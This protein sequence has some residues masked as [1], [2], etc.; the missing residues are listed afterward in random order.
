MLLLLV[1]WLVL[2]KDYDRS[3]IWR[4]L[5]IN[6]LFFTTTSAGLIVWPAIVVTSEG[7]WMGP[8]EKFCRVGL[9]FSIPSVLLLGALWAGS[10]DWAPWYNIPGQGL[11]MNNDFLFLRNIILLLFFWACAFYFS[12]T[13]S[14]R[15]RKSSAIALILLFVITFSLN[16][17]DFI[18]NLNP[19]WHSMMIGGYVFSAG[20]YSGAVAWALLSVLAGRPDRRSLTDIGELIVSFCLMTTYL[21]FSQLLPI[22]YENLPEESTFLVPLLNFAWRKI[23]WVVVAVVYLSPVILLMTKWSKRSYLF[24][25][26]VSIILLAGLWVEKWWLVTAVFEKNTV[27]I[28]WPELLA[29]GVCLSFIVSVFPLVAGYDVK[30][31]ITV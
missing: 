31:R 3:R 30:E 27:V 16:G 7:E 21:M 4:T 25:G 17:F 14:A 23:S 2:A 12:F 5:L 10:P 20:L 29:A 28:G 8:L 1:T 24:M 26:V 15:K 19:K 18:M 22:W 13:P 11:W 9:A 6:Y